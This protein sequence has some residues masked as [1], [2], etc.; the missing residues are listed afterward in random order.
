MRRAPSERSIKMLFASSGGIC[1]FPG[2]VTKLVDPQSHALLGEMCHISA[3]SSGGPR[4]DPTQSDA[5]RNE[6]EN[7]IILC[8]THHSLVDQDASSYMAEALRR[9]KMQHEN[10]VRA[11]LDAASVGIGDRQAADFARQAADESVDF[12][13]VIALPKELA[14]VRKF[15]PE[16]WRV[17]VGSTSSR[18]YYRG[19]VPPAHGGS[20]RVVVTMLHSMGNLQAAHATAD[21]IREWNPRFI[22]VNGIA[23]GL[24]REQQDFGDIVA[25]DSIVYY[26]LA[27]VRS[28]GQER[29][30]RQ[31]QAV[32]LQK[33]LWPQLV[34]SQ[35]VLQAQHLV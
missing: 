26:E 18:S 11:I 10:R 15:F 31:F 19:T 29:R 25:S 6:A 17:A 2:C 21:L 8:P 35:E 30:N 4:F 27:K 1:A 12:A 3:A 13:I 9:M 7:L 14:A 34:A 24:S 28:G 16:L 32:V 20:Y 33:I 5:E 23:G 22:L